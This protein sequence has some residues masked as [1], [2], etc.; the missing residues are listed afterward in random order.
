MPPWVMG[1]DVRTPPPILPG[2]AYANRMDRATT[3]H[4]NT[5]LARRFQAAG[6]PV[7][8]PMSDAERADWERRQ[9]EADSQPRTYGP[10]HA[11]T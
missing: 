9:A 4:H 7:P 11:A 1:I 2:A 10:K 5:P 3:D 8:P 6:L